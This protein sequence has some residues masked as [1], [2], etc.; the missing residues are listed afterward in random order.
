VTDLS[1]NVYSFAADSFYQL[2]NNWPSGGAATVTE[3][4]A[5]TTI[6]DRN[7]NII[8]MTTNS[9]TSGG[10]PIVDSA[11]RSVISASSSGG[12]L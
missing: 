12:T 6:E 4:I 5:P 10:L 9:Q 7:G 3:M 1:G 2:P 8:T 11:G